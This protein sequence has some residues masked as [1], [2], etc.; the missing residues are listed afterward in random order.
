[1]PSSASGQ[2]KSNSALWLANRAGKM[3]LSRPLGTTRRDA[4]EEVSRTE[5]M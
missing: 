1:M 2:D 3:E 5:A 4:Q